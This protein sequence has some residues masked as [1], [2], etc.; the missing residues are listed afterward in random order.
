MWS[1]DSVY[2]TALHFSGYYH[3]ITDNRHTMH[4]GVELHSA[5]YKENVNYEVLVVDWRSSTVSF[6]DLLNGSQS[7]NKT[8]LQLPLM[9]KYSNTVGRTVCYRE[10]CRHRQWRISDLCSKI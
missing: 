7:R 6:P 3:T 8:M 5:L 10:V 4:K 2:H 9:Y 1:T